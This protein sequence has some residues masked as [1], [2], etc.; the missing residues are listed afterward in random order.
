M[1]EV[2]KCRNT[3]HQFL[4]FHFD[5]DKILRRPGAVGS[6]KKEGKQQI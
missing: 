1:S 4:Y 6:E 2:K 3:C 5:L